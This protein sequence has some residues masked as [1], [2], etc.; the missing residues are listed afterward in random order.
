MPQSLRATIGRK[1]IDLFSTTS[2]ESQESYLTNT[3][4][5]PP[6]PSPPHSTFARLYNAAASPASRFCSA[7]SLAITITK[8]KYAMS[9]NQSS[10][11]KAITYKNLLVS[12]SSYLTSH[13]NMDVIVKT[14]MNCNVF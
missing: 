6:P 13:V 4:D 3:G 1:R 8:V 11:L 10:N 7:G 2:L 14:T 9:M 5:F 12:R